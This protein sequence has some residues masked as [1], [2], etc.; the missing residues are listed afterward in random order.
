MKNLKKSKAS[1]GLNPVLTSVI[2]ILGPTAV[3]LLAYLSYIYQKEYKISQNEDIANILGAYSK[4][5]VETHRQKVFNGSTLAYVT[6]WNSDGYDIAKKFGGKFDLIS[7]VWFQIAESDIKDQYKIQGDHDIDPQWIKEI[8]NWN[9]ERNNDT[10]VPK[11]VPRF[12]LMVE[13]KSGIENLIKSSSCRSNLINTIMLNINFKHIMVKFDGIV[14]ECANSL[15]LQELIFELTVALHK[16][17]LI[18]ILVLPPPSSLIIPEIDAQVIVG[19]FI[20]YIQYVDFVSLMT[21]DY[22][23]RSNSASGPNAPIEWMKSEVKAICKDQ[24]SCRKVK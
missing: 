15:F 22:S 11:I 9:S 4:F 17:R 8:I 20:K 13:T 24:K 18:M 3:V 14:F 23:I 12:Q 10:L 21:Y 2:R 6:P 5:K 19:Q 7:P 16:Q 1:N